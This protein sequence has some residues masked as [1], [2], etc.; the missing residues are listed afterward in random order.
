MRPNKATTAFLQAKNKFEET[1]N[2]YVNF[3][4][5]A[6]TGKKRSEILEANLSTE[7]L[8][9]AAAH[10]MAES[11]RAS[12]GE[13]L[14]FQYLALMD[15][16]RGCAQES[17]DKTSGI[18]T[19][20]EETFRAFILDF[21]SASSALTLTIIANGAQSPQLI[22]GIPKLAAVER[23]VIKLGKYGLPENTRHETSVPSRN[24]LDW[25]CLSPQLERH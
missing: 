24:A 14:F 19:F 8:L 22:P 2:A 12:L 5:E 16:E 4:L 25:L 7:E 17:G 3:D 18:Y 1:T 9:R 21:F 20:T 13:N 23:S 10:Y 6:E 15:L 11:Y